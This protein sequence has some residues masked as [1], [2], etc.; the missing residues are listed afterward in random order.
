MNFNE[1]VRRRY[2]LLLGSVQHGI[3]LR[4]G[5][6]RKPRHSDGVFENNW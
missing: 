5:I 1:G 4:M 2:S 6:K 3:E